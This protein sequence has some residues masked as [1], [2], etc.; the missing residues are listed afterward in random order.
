MTIEKFLIN[1]VKIYFNRR[2]PL[3]RD[4]DYAMRA[5]ISSLLY[6]GFRYFK[7]RYFKVL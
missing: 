4:T 5:V 3:F 7:F 6:Q 2:I 1:F